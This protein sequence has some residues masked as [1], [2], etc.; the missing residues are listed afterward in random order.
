MQIALTE[1]YQSIETL[2]TE[3]LPDFAVLNGRNGACKTQ[4]PEA[5]K[6]G[7]VV[8]PGV[9]TDKIEMYNMVSF[10]PPNTSVANR[11]ANQFAINTADAYLLA[12]P[13]ELPLI[14]TEAE[15]FERFAGDLERESG[16]EA[17]DDFARSLRE[18][19]RRLQDF[20]VFASENRS[21]LYHVELYQ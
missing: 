2:V 18:E 8:V 1:P 19:I 9:S 16:I 14:E 21:A 15:I 5:L 13:G 11:Y 10:R 17:Y 7:S 6:Q 20:V 12:I 3:E 4:L